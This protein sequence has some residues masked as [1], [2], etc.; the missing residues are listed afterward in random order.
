MLFQSYSIISYREEGDSTEGVERKS[1]YIG[2]VQ[3]FG[4]I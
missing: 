2:S 3:L 4:S 1:V